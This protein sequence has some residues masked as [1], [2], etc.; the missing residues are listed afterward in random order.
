MEIPMEIPWHPNFS[1]GNHSEIMF[2]W[3]NHSEIMLNQ[4]SSALLMHLNPMKKLQH[5]TPFLHQEAL[6]EVA[7]ALKMGPG[8]WDRKPL[9]KDRMGWKDGMG[10]G[11]TCCSDFFGSTSALFLMCFFCSISAL[12][13][14]CF[15]CSTGTCYFCFCFCLMNWSCVPFFGRMCGFRMGQFFDG[16][17]SDEDMW[18][19]GLLSCEA[20]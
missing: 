16:G 13:Y 10:W 19:K 4:T 7:K 14:F 1:W 18:F 17:L 8:T 5:S 9:K 6:P 2:S 11:I 12:V 15:F 3:L 20:K